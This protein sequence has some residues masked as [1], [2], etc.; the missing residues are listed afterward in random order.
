MIPVL[1][2]SVAQQLQKI[3]ADYSEKLSRLSEEDFSYRS[4]PGKWSRKEEL[5]HIIDSAHNNLRRLVVSQ[6]ENQPGIVYDQN[7]WVKAF[8]YHHQ[9]AQQLVMLWKLLNIQFVEV[10]KTMPEKDFQLLCNTGKDK[11]EL[12]SLQ[13]LAEDYV[14]HLLHHLHHLLGLEEIPY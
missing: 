5:G 4:A 2:I 8:N 1:Q 14:R 9:P 3:I 10:L 12:H 13:W 11:A 6:Y 7:F